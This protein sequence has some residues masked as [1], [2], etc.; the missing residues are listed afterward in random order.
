MKGLSLLFLL[1]MSSLAGWSR[2]V[3]WPA[4]IEPN[5]RFKPNTDDFPLSQGQEWFVE[6]SYLIML[7]NVDSVDYGFKIYVTPDLRTSDIT[8]KRPDLEW[9][10]GAR[11]AIGRYLPHHDHWDISLITTYLYNESRDRAHVKMSTTTI[12]ALEQD[13]A[14]VLGYGAFLDNQALKVKT[15]W[16]LN[17]FTWDLQVRRQYILSS[18]VTF[19]PFIG[20]RLPLVYQKYR[21]QSDG[22][23]Y[24]EITNDSFLNRVPFTIRDHFWG[25][26]PRIGYDISYKFLN[27]WKFLGQLAVSFI[28]SNQS[29]TEKGRG[30][31]NDNSTLRS[32]PS[33]LKYH[34]NITALRT[35]IEAKIGLG[36]EKWVR[37]NTVRIAP[38]FVFEMSDWLDL[39][40][41]SHF[42]VPPAHFG[43]VD[44][45]FKPEERT[46][47]FGLMGF[48]L[49]LQIDF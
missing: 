33:Q 39:I 29:I 7:P 26:G 9:G 45:L 49:N 11:V 6:P 38:S 22:I 44:Y 13:P 35:N 20:I 1:M 4:Q 23:F 2:H 5:V 15:Q 28:Y 31:V 21:I 27:H 43:T 32:T 10:S 46:G 40:H 8:I 24:D 25:G 12:S 16:L 48:A 3:S 37:Q 34:Q 47:D 17:Y 36:W 18:Q 41:W 42:V 19:E 30:F 14:L